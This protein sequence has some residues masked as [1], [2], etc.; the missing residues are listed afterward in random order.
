MLQQISEDRQIIS[1]FLFAKKFMRRRPMP[2][3]TGWCSHA[4]PSPL[5][6]LP[7]HINSRGPWRALRCFPHTA[8]ARINRALDYP[9]IHKQYTWRTTDLVTTKMRCKI[10]AP[11]SM[12]EGEGEIHNS[13]VYT[14]PWYPNF[15]YHL[16]RMFHKSISSRQLVPEQCSCTHKRYIPNASVRIPMHAFDVRQK[17]F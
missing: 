10:V 5:A 1:S 11:R 7:S 12:D 13:M 17:Q 14:A 8:L 3:L 2:G 6:C 9:S 4:G 16:S 15:G